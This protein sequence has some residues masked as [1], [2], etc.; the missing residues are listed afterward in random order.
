MRNFTGR[1][2][3]PHALLFVWG[4]GVSQ[5]LAKIGGRGIDVESTTPL[6]L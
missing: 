6:D 4:G 3:R 1:E 5:G 2:Y